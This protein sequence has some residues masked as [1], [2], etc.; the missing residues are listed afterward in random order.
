LNV[1]S[2]GKGAAGG[3][4]VITYETLINIDNSLLT[5]LSIYNKGEFDS[6]DIAILKKNLGI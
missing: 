4:R 2:K 1:K 3:A 5:L 6:I